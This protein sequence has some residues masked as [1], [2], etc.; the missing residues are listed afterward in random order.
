MGDLGVVRNGL[1]LDVRLDIGI[2]L[3]GVWLGSFC[4]GRKD[5]ARVADAES[6]GGDDDKSEEARLESGIGTEMVRSDLHS[7]KANEQG[8]VGDEVRVSITL[9][10][11]VRPVDA[12]PKDEDDGKSQEAE[13]ELEA[14][15]NGH[16]ASAA[17]VAKQV[18]AEER[19][20]GEEHNDLEDEAGHGDIDADLAGAGAGGGEGAAGGLQDEADEVEGDEDPVEI[21]WIEAGQLRAKMVN[22]GGFVSKS[23]AITS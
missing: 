14:H 17:E 1:R 18:V 21:L 15:V 6:V 2:N 11:L 4:V 10:Q 13:E 8:L 20:K 23:F 5:E 22:A 9:A 12:A 3:G 7:L 16:G 19:A